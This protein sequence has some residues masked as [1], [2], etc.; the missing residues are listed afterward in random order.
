MNDF[1]PYYE[2]SKTHVNIKSHNPFEYHEEATRIN[3]QD[4]KGW[5]GLTPPL[6]KSP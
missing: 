4:T 3:P 2:F 5:Q 1:S 6:K